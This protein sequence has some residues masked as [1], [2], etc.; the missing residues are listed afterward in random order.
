MLQL[1]E[2]FRQVEAEVVSSSGNSIH[3]IWE[4]LFSPPQMRA[5]KLVWVT[6]WHRAHKLVL[7]T[8]WHWSCISVL[9]TQW[10]QSRQFLSFTW[11]VSRV[12]DKKEAILAQNCQF[13]LHIQLGW[14][15]NRVFAWGKLSLLRAGV[16]LCFFSG[17]SKQVWLNKL[18]NY[19]TFCLYL[20][21]F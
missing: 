10:H 21:S 16:C 8:Q 2:F 19:N 11:C 3:Q 5:H 9:V 7:V 18:L 12:T 17:P 1:R 14:F 20:F 13:R 6:Q 15:E 4:A